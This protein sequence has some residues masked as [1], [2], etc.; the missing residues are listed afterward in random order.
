MENEKTDLVELR[1]KLEAPFMEE[2]NGKKV[3]TCKWLPKQAVSNNTKF[4][5]IPYIDRTMVFNRMDDVFGTDGWHSNL[6]ELRDGS[7]LCEL[8]ACIN[9]VWVTKTDVGTKTAVEAEKGAASDSIK[10]A[11]TQYGIGR[12]LNDLPNKYVPAKI[13]VK[14][15]AEPTDDHGKPLYGDQLHNFINRNMS[16]GHGL[17]Y[18]V[19]VVMPEL[20]KREDV[21]KLWNDLK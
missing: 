5:C 10:R 15:K 18:S 1:K 7:F 13:N 4:M 9:G 11:A 20:Y 8:S 17:L 12:Y 6:K 19:L 16:L 21:K 14:G 3:H 2:Y